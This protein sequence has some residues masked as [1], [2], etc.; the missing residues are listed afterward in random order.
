M[1]GLPEVSSKRPRR[2]I[3]DDL[4][5]GVPERLTERLMR[6][7]GV[8]EDDL[9]DMDVLAQR[10][11]AFINALNARKREAGLIEEE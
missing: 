2:P 10:W 9:A 6:G 8:N 5:L 1:S 7:I 3:F 11:G 4:V